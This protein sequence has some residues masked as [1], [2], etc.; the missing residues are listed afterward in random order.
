MTG[1]K[2]GFTNK[3]ASVADLASM[4]RAALAVLKLPEFK[5]GNWGRTEEDMACDEILFMLTGHSE[6]SSF[7]SLAATL[8]LAKNERDFL[9]RWSGDGSDDYIRT[10][11][12][13]VRMATQSLLD[14][15]S[16]PGA[17]ERVDEADAYE[18]LMAKLIKA[19]MDKA[20]AGA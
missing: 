2:E 14:A 19:N 6:R 7:P 9:G 10:A 5:D 3:V 4:G 12:R 1:D 13:I 16:V 8:G 15:L 18:K 17:Y 11:K 20:K